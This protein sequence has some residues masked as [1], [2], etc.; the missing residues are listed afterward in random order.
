MVLTALGPVVTGTALSVY[1]VIRTEDSADGALADDLASTWLEVDKN[2]ARHVLVCTNFGVVHVNPLE[3]L[4]V[5][6]AVNTIALD[7]VLFTEGF[8]EFGTWA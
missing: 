2:R 8:P 4:V 7:T 6:T 1:E 3:L 5:I